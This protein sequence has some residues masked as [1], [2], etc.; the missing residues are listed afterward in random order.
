MKAI[1]GSLRL[2]KS[3]LSRRTGEQWTAGEACRFPNLLRHLIHCSHLPCSIFCL[4]GKKSVHDS[5]FSR[6]L[7]IMSW[8]GSPAF[9]WK[10]EFQKKIYRVSCRELGFA[11]QFWLKDETYQAANA[12]WLK[13]HAELV[14]S[15]KWH[16]H[17][18]AINALKSKVD[19]AA[20]LGFMMKLRA[21]WSV[22][23]RLSDCPPMNRRFW[24][25]PRSSLL[26]TW[27]C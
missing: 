17:E 14:H 10:K 3:K 13:K 27:K 18:D 15:E 2:W 24:K 5:R 1:C 21:F 16:P 11:E 12:W 26:K 6:P 25:P 20:K 23:K 8:E 19:I 7:I 9:R 4:D 22:L